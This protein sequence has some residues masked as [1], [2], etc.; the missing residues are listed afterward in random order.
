MAIRRVLVAVDLRGSTAEVVRAAVDV[1]GPLR[2]SVVLYTVVSA[3]PGVNPFAEAP[4]GR[5][6]EEVL[7]ANAYGDLE[8]FVLMLEQAGVQVV[9]DLGH[10]DPV[11]GI[12]EAI[13][14]HQPDMVVI[15]THGRSGMARLI[16]GSVA[17]QVLRTATVPVLVVRSPAAALDPGE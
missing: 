9:R 14:R 13:L 2:A 3:A 6:N 12:Q 5:S 17:E 15:G 7:D 16:L 1:A 8:P 10:G 11:T 4:D